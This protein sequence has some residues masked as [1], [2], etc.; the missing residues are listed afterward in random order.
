M[1]VVT[2]SSAP[3]AFG[4]ELAARVAGH[5]GFSLID[6]KS[7]SHIRDEIN[8]D[9]SPVCGAKESCAWD[10]GAPGTRNG[11]N[12]GL[13]SE[14]IA[15]MAAEQDLVIIGMGAQGL[16]HDRP[17]TLHVRVIAPRRFRIRQ[18]QISEGLSFR[19][20]GRRIR[21]IEEQRALDLRSAY[22]MSTTDPDLY[23]LALRMD[24]LSVAQALKLIVAA[25]DEM[26]LREVPKDLIVS[27]LLPAS[28]DKRGGGR[29]ANAA[30][31]EFAGFLEFYHI[32]YEY[33]P[34][35]FPL[36]FDGDGK[37]VEAFTPDFYLPEQDLYIELTTM[38]QSLVTRKNR[39]VRKLR[40][41]YPEV[42]ILIFY[43][44][45]FYSLMA[46]YGLLAGR[47]EPSKERISR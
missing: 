5:L 25:V 9:E 35:C 28:P 3:G 14:F 42:R 29:F 10:G 22:G 27:G 37:V 26:R 39:K 11:D 32:P 31:N 7:L 12:A 8:S 36:A 46:K 23:D 17:G 19:E 38:K 44:K 16:F 18:M 34:R 45:D 1:A 21:S 30:E 41:L 13:S 33:E 47:N 15:Q 24:R 40:R 4:E 6:K 20:A 2:I 43:Q